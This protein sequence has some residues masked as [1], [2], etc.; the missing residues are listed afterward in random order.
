[1]ILHIIQKEFMV[2]LRR[3]AV[4]SGISL[5]LFS[6]NFICYLT[7]SLRQ[8]SINEATW[9]ALFWLTI[10]FANFNGISKS[11]IGE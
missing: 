8:G 10:L 7:F 3:N 1:M 5:Y 2:E 4:N 11:F 9:S 6:I